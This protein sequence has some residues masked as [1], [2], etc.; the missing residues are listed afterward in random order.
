MT[1]SPSNRLLLA[2]A[3]ATL[4]T[5][6]AGGSSSSGT[7]GPAGG[8]ISSPSG[9]ALQVPA[10]ALSQPVALRIVEVAPGPGGVARVQLE[11][12]G[13]ALAA[14]ATLSFELQDGNVVVSEVEHAAEGEV[15]H[16]LAKRRHAA[17]SS[18]V[19]QVEVEVEDLGEVEVEHGATCD[20]ACDAGTEC[21]DGVCKADDVGDD[22]GTDPA[23]MPTDPT[24]P[25][26]DGGAH[27]AGHP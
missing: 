16:G 22:A 6:C 18:G 8:T 7:V 9:V 15:K 13:T 25:A 20:A 1:T 21:D 14:P 26:D 24:A 5:A 23:G 19:V 3:L 17:D 12:R 27:P 2:T 10:G 4:A 11:P